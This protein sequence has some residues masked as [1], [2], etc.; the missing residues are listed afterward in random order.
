MNDFVSPNLNQPTYRDFTTT[1]K[2]Y[3]SGATKAEDQVSLIP[4]VMSLSS[5]LDQPAT[6][7]VA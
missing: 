3:R 2:G 5:P 6:S 1:P 7:P 4:L